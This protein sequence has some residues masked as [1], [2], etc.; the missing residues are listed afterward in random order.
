[1]EATNQ[2]NMVLQLPRFKFDGRNRQEFRRNWPQVARHYDIQGIIDGTEPQPA[3]DAEDRADWDLRNQ[4]ALDKLKYY[5]SDSIHAI[6][7]KGQENLT[8]KDYY[9]TMNTL[10]LRTTTRSIVQLEK[11]LNSCRMRDGRLLEWM[12]AMDNIYVEFAQAGE[13]KSDAAM[14]AHAMAKCGR[15]WEAIG[16]FLG[17]DDGVSYVQWQAAMLEKEREMEETGT[18]GVRDLASQLGSNNQSN[19]G[20]Y[21]TSTQQAWR[22]S[23][24]PMRGGR[25]GGRYPSRGRHPITYFTQGHA[26]GNR[27]YGNTTRTNRTTNRGRNYR[28][29]SNTNNTQRG[30]YTLNAARDSCYT[31]GQTGH[32]ARNC[33]SNTTCFRCGGSGHLA[34]DCAT[35]SNRANATLTTNVTSYDIDEYDYTQGF[36]AINMMIT[37]L[38]NDDAAKVFSASV[39]QAHV[40][41]LDSCCTRHMTGYYAL[42]NARPNRVPVMFGNKEKLFS[43]HVGTMVLS[44]GVELEDCLFVPGLMWTLISEPRIEQEGGSM[45]SAKG[46]RT[47]FDASGALII[48]AALTENTYLLS[49]QTYPIS[50]VEQANYALADAPIANTADLWHCRL[51]H[52][53]YQDMVKLKAV[54]TGIEFSGELSFCEDCARVKSTNK[55][56]IN[57]GERP[58]KP[59]QTICFDVKKHARSSGGFEYSL[60][61]WDKFS[62]EEWTF[63]LRRKSDASHKLQCFICSLEN[64]G[65]PIYVLEMCVSDHGGE[66][67]DTSLQ[68]FLEMRG[69][70]HMTA[71]SHT[72]N[73]N[74]A[75]SRMKGLNHMQSLLL[76]QANF[77]LS[78]WPLARQCATFI[79]NR[80]PKRSNYANK[81][82]YEMFYGRAP[83]LSSMRAFG[84]P[85]F[86]HVPSAMRSKLDDAAKPAVFVG[87]SEKRRAY[88]VI[89]DGREIVSYARSVIF[90]EIP[91]I[92][93]LSGVNLLS[94]P[95]DP[96]AKQAEG[97]LFL[98]ST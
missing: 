84:S 28:A 1:M 37:V 86:V 19:E 89:E 8:A 93:K 77:P 90:N 14:K 49:Q 63:P 62:G 71:P 41:K 58:T 55:P 11:C 25:R 9:D 23:G 5:V 17:Q 72:P 22:G 96:P 70:F 47:I 36:G 94:S 3:A 67:M 35:Q 40:A 27:A 43:T 4:L 7:W 97:R 85:C 15:K 80:T 53:N 91:I 98:L 68:E 33:P 12:C 52:L 75:E 38:E 48:S 42:K 39:D 10:L 50:Y 69:I 73:Y 61:I 2:A 59:R 57:A 79:R 87:Y 30:G 88:M 95:F 81:T 78:K 13:P 74:P 45:A 21:S 65:E 6:V 16:I 82:P 32:L 56:Y 51:G 46:T 29:Q 34:R 64:T 24:N 92:N 31:C 66:F 60:D 76:K 44:N 54:A 18:I 20:A 26:T 83:D